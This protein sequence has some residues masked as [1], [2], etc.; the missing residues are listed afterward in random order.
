MEGLGIFRIASSVSVVPDEYPEVRQTQLIRFIRTTTSVLIINSIIHAQVT[1]P[2]QAMP[3]YSCSPAPSPITMWH[4]ENEFDWTVDYTE[5]LHKNIMYGM[6]KNSDLVKLKEEAGSHHDRW[7]A[8][9]DSFGLL[10][11]LVADIIN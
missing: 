7:Y 3:E 1:T 9:A 2:S 6:L 11:T 5:Y 4:A 10:V 8:Y